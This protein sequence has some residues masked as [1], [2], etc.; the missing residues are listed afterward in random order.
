MIL[1]WGYAADVFESANKVGIIG[2]AALLGYVA[3]VYLGVA[4]EEL[5][6]AANSDAL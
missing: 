4:V 3:E 2:E 5:F 1:G 6:C